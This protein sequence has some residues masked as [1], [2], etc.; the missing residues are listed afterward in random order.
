MR[1]K[2][3]IKQHRKMYLRERDQ[4]WRLHKE[5]KKMKEINPIID[6]FFLD[7]MDEAKNYISVSV[8]DVWL[9]FYK[10]I[11]IGVRDLRIN[12]AAFLKCRDEVLPEDGYSHR[13]EITQGIV[14]GAMK[15]A[16]PDAEP[17]KM[18]VVEDLTALAMQ[19]V[20][21]SMVKH[22]DSALRLNT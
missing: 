19:W 14:E 13:H 8:G 7:D 20:A 21:D 4:E 6:F 12:H 15:E 22:I 1:L 9:Y 10:E 11:L 2:K 16:Y 5:S 3:W 18:L 17:P